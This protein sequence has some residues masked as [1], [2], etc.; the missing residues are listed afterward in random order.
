M[1]HALRFHIRK[2][3]DGDPSRYTKLSMRLDSILKVLTGKW[4][5]LSLA[6]EKA[7]GRNNR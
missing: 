7:D 2:N 3:F 4:E 6:L 1:E 5:Q